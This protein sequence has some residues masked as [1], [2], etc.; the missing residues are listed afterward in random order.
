M[1][2]VVQRVARAR[3]TVA[4]E[5]TGAIERGLFVLLGVGGDDR[6]EDAD[7]LAAR[8]PVLR[9]FPN[10]AGKFDRSLIDIAG[11]LLAVSQFTLYAD[12]SKGR[13]PSFLDAAL[14]EKAVPLYER[15]VAKVAEQGIRTATGRFGA[16]MQI[17]LVA[18]GPVTL[19][20]DSNAVRKTPAPA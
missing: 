12:T 17:E 11:G 15:F 16:D 19:T 10:E 14:P 18:D 1:K 13:R 3:V 20:L 8:I 2:A 4:G 7:L 9:I 5:Q 6:E